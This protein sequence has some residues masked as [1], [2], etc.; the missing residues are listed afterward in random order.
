MRNPEPHVGEEFYIV[1]GEHVLLT[2]LVAPGAFPPVPQ[3][4]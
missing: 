4:W 3:P 1:K 2:D